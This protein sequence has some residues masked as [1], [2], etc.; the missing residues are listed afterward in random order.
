[1]ID[2]L[3]SGPQVSRL[4]A[5]RSSLPLPMATLLG[6]ESLPF[7]FSHLPCLLQPPPFLPAFSPH[8]QGMRLG[9]ERS[10]LFAQMLQNTLEPTIFTYKLQ[11][12]LGSNAFDWFEIVTAK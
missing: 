10:I 11:R 2:P 5:Q 6:L 1:M 12:R 8:Q 3:L 9:Q 7:S 4:V